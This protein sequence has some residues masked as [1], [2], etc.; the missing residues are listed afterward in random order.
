M[1]RE[2]GGLGLGLGLGLLNWMCG[3]REGGLDGGRVERTAER[4][5]R[6]SR[7]CTV[8][9]RWHTPTLAY[10]KVGGHRDLGRACSCCLGRA[11]SRTPLSHMVYVCEAV[12]IHPYRSEKGA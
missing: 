2:G 5:F 11:S 8:E 10:V 12:R 1:W 3:E 6:K 7:A 4:Q 9:R